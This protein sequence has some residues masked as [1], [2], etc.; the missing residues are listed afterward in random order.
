MFGSSFSL[1]PKESQGL[2]VLTALGLDFSEAMRP[3]SYP[4]AHA[5]YEWDCLWVWENAQRR[6]AIRRKR[7]V[8]MPTVSSVMAVGLAASVAVVA[9]VGRASQVEGLVE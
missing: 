2:R 6:M 3:S 1:N 4:R 9:K 8:G 7:G 5:V